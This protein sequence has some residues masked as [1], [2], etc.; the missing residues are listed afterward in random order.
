MFQ[1]PAESL[2]SR[3]SVRQIVRE[4]LD[5]QKIGTRKERD[6]MV[7]D[8]LEKVGLPRSAADKFPFEFSGGQR[9]RIGI[10]RAISLN[11]QLVVCDEPVSALDVSIQAQVLN[12][13][14]DLRQELGLS[15]LFV[16]HDLKVVQH[17]CERVMI[18]YLGYVVEEV[19]CDDLETDVRHPYSKAL[20]GAIPVDDPRDRV[21][22]EVLEGDVPS[23]ITLPTGC[24]FSTRCPKV[25][26]I[27]KKE[28]P[29]LVTIGKS[30]KVAC[31]L[32][33]GD[34]SDS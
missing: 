13:L 33:E 11:P 1:D 3:F 27:C 16:S 19:S 24:P 22:R 23:P 8:L 6:A 26:A 10:A 34:G 9:Q 32:V 20:L 2:N 5:I 7:E 30:H 17:F 12:L 28:N 14:E 25:E 15:Y 29:P 4:P 31:H 21:E 18:M